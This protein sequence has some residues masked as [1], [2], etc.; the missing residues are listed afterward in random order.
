MARK[1]EIDGSAAMV[2]DYLAGG[3]EKRWK[4]KEAKK[5][6]GCGGKPKGK[7]NQQP[8]GG[9]GWLRFCE[10][11]KSETRKGHY[12]YGYNIISY[13]AGQ[14][15]WGGPSIERTGTRGRRRE[16]TNDSA[17]MTSELS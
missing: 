13:C 15:N 12:Q 2:V 17:R 10:T 14:E 8:G 6:G 16:R 3:D 9:R 7:K 4:W 11:K 5:K 1:E